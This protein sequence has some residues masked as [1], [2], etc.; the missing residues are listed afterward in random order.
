MGTLN[1]AESFADLPLRQAFAPTVDPHDFSTR[2][3]GRIDDMIP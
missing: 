2:M 3:Q 1:D